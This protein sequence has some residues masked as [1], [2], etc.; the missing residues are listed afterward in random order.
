MHN[1]KLYIVGIGLAVMSLTGCTAGFLDV[2]SKRE[3]TTG[4]FYRTESDA[5][6][7][8][9]GCYDG[10]QC[11]T[12]SQACAFY[13]AS[14]IMADECFAGMGNTDARNY[15]VIDRFDATQSPSDMNLLETE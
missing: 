11:T 3:S 1:M 15:Q 4:N 8:L 9:I 7:A 6:R 13:F 10:W 14:Q 12:S 5:W 2:E